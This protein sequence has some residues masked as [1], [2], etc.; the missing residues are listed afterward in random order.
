MSDFIPLAKPSVTEA[1][2]EAVVG[3]MRSGWLTRGPG[4]GE[5][6]RAFAE[7]VGAPEALA[8][9]SCTAALHLAVLGA[10]VGPGDEV[11]VPTLTFVSTA[12]VVVHAGG[13]PVFAD[14]RQ[15]TCNLDVASVE[16]RITPRTKAVI[17]VHYA[18]QPCELDELGR[19]CAR[20][21][22]VLIETPRTPSARSTTARASAA[23]TA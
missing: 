18:G 2:I 23:R 16:A 22:L 20:R 1:E 5:F 17:A 19:L 7:Y 4:V 12:N 10:G 11:I 13:T 3:A 6:E 21:N 9:S 14:V 8:V 15:A